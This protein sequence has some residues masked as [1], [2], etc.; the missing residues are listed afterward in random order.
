MAKSIFVPG[1]ISFASFLLA[2]RSFNPKL[3]HGY[4][5]SKLANTYNES[6]KFNIYKAS[7][8][9]VFTLETFIK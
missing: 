1:F 7:V 4:Y 9:V 2:D 3:T 5:F 8:P 6:L